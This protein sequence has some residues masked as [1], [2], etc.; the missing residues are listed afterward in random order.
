MY[1]SGQSRH[2]ILKF[3]FYYTYLFMVGALVYFGYVCGRLFLF[4][5]PE[6]VV[7]LLTSLLLYMK[8]THFSFGAEDQHVYF[9]FCFYWGVGFLIRFVLYSLPHI[10]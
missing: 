1:F 2:F 6:K 5:C 7:I 10:V 4:A 9:V 8:V 3:H